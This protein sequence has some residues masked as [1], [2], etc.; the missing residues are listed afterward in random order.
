MINTIDVSKISFGDLKLEIGGDYY[1]VA[2]PYTLFAE[3]I[4][5]TRTGNDVLSNDPL[6]KHP[7]SY[8]N[9]CVPVVM[10]KEVHTYYYDDRTILHFRIHTKDAIYSKDKYRMPDEVAFASSVGFVSDMPSYKDILNGASRYLNIDLHAVRMATN[11]KYR[12]SKKVN[13]PKFASW[14]VTD[15]QRDARN[16]D[17]VNVASNISEL[18]SNDTETNNDK[19]LNELTEST[20][21]REPEDIFV[22]TAPSTLESANIEGDSNDASASKDG[23]TN[24]QLDARYQ[25]RKSKNKFAN[26]TNKV[27]DKKSLVNSATASELLEMSQ[28]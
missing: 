21:V 13:V 10:M 24:Q 2:D 15:N 19:S 1:L 3:N 11:E 27:S 18:V 17:I 20:P 22:E 25:P 6:F 8:K 23:K 16:R 7:V 9:G 12:R 4:S 5:F 28:T 26:G 14:F